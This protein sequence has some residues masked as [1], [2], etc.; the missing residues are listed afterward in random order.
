MS[1]NFIPLTAPFI[2]DDDIQ[3]ME[4][5][6]RAKAISQGS[7][8]ESFES[9]FSDLLGAPGAVAVNSCTSALILA[10][11]TLR[12]GSGSEVVLPS[13]TCLAVLNAVVQTGATPRLVDNNYD[14]EKMDYNISDKVVSEAISD[15]TRAIIVPHMFGVAAEVDHIISSGIP[16]I[17]DITLSLG[18]KYKGRIV[19]SFGDISVCSFHSS[20]VITTGEG[21]MLTASTPALYKRAIYLNGWECEQAAA[22]L[23]YTDSVD[24]E[25]RY[26][27]HLSDILA[28]FGLSQLAKL[29]SFIDRRR[30]LGYRYSERLSKFS[31]IQVPDASE[32][33][34]IFYRYLVAL[35]EGFDIGQIIRKFAADGIE[36]GR[37]VYPSLHNF[38]RLP[39]ESFPNAER[40]MRT[41]LSIPLY[42]ALTNEQVEHILSVSER[43]FRKEGFE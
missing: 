25:L 8:A 3:Q 30:E 39:A 10:L 7:I 29:K 4:K 12:V 31:R 36:I 14:T 19:G 13:Y 38:L 27:F 20:K 28:S 40:A 41:L 22:R 32:E 23:E 37:G 9:A 1:G 24:Y 11:R 5:A 16:V 15:K 43:I 2:G 33:N 26:N 17:E 21:G 6:A 18:A 35:P 42:P 34:N